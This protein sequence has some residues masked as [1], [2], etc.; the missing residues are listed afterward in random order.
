MGKVVLTIAQLKWLSEK[1][2]SKTKWLFESNLIFSILKAL[3][4]LGSIC[5][6][7]GLQLQSQFNYAKCLLPD[8]IFPMPKIG[9]EKC[10]LD[11]NPRYGPDSL[12][13]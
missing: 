2:P 12:I 11:L 7:L 1:K 6:T 10:K 8:V 13:N 3:Q 5:L 9:I 4:G